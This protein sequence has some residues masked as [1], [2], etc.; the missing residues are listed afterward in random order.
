MSRAKCYFID[1][2]MYFYGS[3]CGSVGTVVTSDSRGPRFL[4]SHGQIY[5]ERLMSIV[6][7]GRK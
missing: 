7:I 2:K 4:S 6:L 1:T 3:G 5:I